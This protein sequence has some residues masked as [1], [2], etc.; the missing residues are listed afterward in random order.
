M[1][2]LLFTILIICFS[3]AFGQMNFI[4]TSSTLTRT[5]DGVL[6][7]QIQ[8]LTGKNLLGNLII[9]AKNSQS[10]QPLFIIYSQ[11][12]KVPNGVSSSLQYN[13]LSAKISFSQNQE[14]KLIS[15]TRKFLSGTYTICF[16]FM[17]TDKLQDEYENCVDIEIAPLTPVSLISPDDMDTICSKR[18]YLS[19]QPPM[20][21]SQAVKYKMFL[22][23]KKDNQTIE[24]LFL[25][26]P[27]I[28]IDGITSSGVVYHS[29]A[30]D[31]QEGKTYVWQVVAY[32][33]SQVISQSE[34]WTFTVQCKDKINDFNDNYRELKTIINGNFYLSTDILKFAFVNNYNVKKLDYSIL[35][36]QNDMKPI[37]R[38]PEVKLI[39]GYNKININLNQIELTENK[40]YLIVVRP[41]NQNEIKV[42]FR[43]VK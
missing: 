43:Y 23:E 22:T 4:F 37:E 8:N 21:L 13:L 20:P 33:S 31:L 35:D 38:V 15:Q 41:F 1:K 12:V 17:P 3:R 7:F 14:A 36:I 32:E 16:K 30:P 26:V 11:E 5:V 29:S 28:N 18:P 27:I 40:D 25:N 19:W 24:S 10:N 42:R 34:I 2:K 9:S 6:N 39:N